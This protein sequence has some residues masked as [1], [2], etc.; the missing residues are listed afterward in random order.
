[1]FKRINDSNIS[2]HESDEDIDDDDLEDYDNE[3]QKDDPD[4]QDINWF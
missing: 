4:V 2:L 1:M 3:Y